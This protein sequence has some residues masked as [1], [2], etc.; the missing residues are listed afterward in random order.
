MLIDSVGEHGA[1]LSE[2]PRPGLAKRSATYEDLLKVPDHFVAEILEGEL[3]ATPRP[4]MPHAVA[5]SALGSE[6]G[7]PFQ[8]GRGGPGGWWILD[9]PEL[10]LGSDVIVPDL[11]G[12][13]RS[14]VPQVP[15]VAAMTI[16]PDWVC[17]ILSPSTEALDRVPKLNAYSRERVAHVWFINPR[18]QTLEVLRLEGARWTVVATHD[19]D[20]SVTVEPFDAVPLDL[21]RLWGHDAPAP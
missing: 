9:E 5:A 16:P 12:W 10:H 6:L 13:R 21:Y 2:M 19:G 1:K 17:E 18:S 15:A 4:A 20:V 14:R 7:G 8:Q 11:A 3:Y